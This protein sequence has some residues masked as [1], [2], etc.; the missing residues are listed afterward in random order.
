[1]TARSALT[2]AERAGERLDACADGVAV[3]G[4]TSV[5]ERIGRERRGGAVFLGQL[6]KQRG[7]EAGQVRVAL[8]KGRDLDDRA[9]RAVTG[10]DESVVWMLDDSYAHVHCEPRDFLLAIAA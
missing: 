9:R 6:G 2:R 8:V 3:D 4:G 1:M 5:G 10:D 7:G